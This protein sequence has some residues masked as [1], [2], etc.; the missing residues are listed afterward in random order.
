MEAGYR[1]LGSDLTGTDTPWEA[2][3]DP[4]VSLSG[5]QFV[6]SDALA[7]A[8]TRPLQRRLRTLAVGDAAW[9][10]VYGGEALYADGDVV[11]RVRSA[12][13][14]FGVGRNLATAYLPVEL[15][16][17]SDLRSTSS[18]PCG[19]R[20]CSG[21]PLREPDGDGV[22]ERAPSIEEVVRR[23]EL[24]RG[25]RTRTSMLSGRAHEPELPGRGRTELAMSSGS[26]ALPR[27]CWRWTA[28]TNATTPRRRPQRASPLSCSR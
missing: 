2:G 11:G 18:G 22:T 3:L 28:R 20:P 17:G 7:D 27:T 25:K 4:F 15:G 1:A 12:A 16:P 10:P 9:E 21:I 19:P 26:R 14:G 6:G 24:F 8:H 5:R 23:I 13:Y